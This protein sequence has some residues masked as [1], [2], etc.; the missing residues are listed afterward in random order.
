VFVVQTRHGSALQMDSVCVRQP[1]NT[2]N[3][4]H[5][6]CKAFKIFNKFN[7]PQVS[8][9]DSRYKIGPMGQKKCQ[10]VQHQMLNP[11]I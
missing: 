6:D 9:S 2:R 1:V 10:S 5:S 11:K 8:K 7:S 4:H 3:I